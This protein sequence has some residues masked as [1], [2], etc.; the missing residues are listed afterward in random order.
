MIK[1]DCEE[2]VLPTWNK[3]KVR[4]EVL[5]GAAIINKIKMRKNVN[6]NAN[7]PMNC[8]VVDVVRDRVEE[9]I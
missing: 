1:D 9:V 7:L 5:V 8:K 6:G 3:G 4:E 2:T